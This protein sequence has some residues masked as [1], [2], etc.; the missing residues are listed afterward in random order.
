[1]NWIQ[2]G[3]VALSVVLALG[4]AYELGERHQASADQAKLQ[5][6]Q[7]MHDQDMNHALIMERDSTYY[8]TADAMGLE[9]FNVL[10]SACLKEK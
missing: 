10:R 5:K 8:K 1:M 3:N 9:Y 2:V 7:D 6:A 4:V